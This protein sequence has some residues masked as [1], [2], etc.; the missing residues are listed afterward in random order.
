MQKTLVP[1]PKTPG[2]RALSH[3]SRRVLLRVWGAA[4]P[5]AATGGSRERSQ[6]GME[7]TFLVICLAHFRDTPGQTDMNDIIPPP[8]APRL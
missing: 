8:G 6:V 2:R 1:L 7:E 4:A 5:V 3:V